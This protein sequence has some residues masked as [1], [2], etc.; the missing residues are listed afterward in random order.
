MSR[1]STQI[2]QHIAQLLDCTQQ[3]FYLNIIVPTIKRTLENK[4]HFLNNNTIVWQRRKKEEEGTRKETSHHSLDKS[5]EKLLTVT[6]RWILH[7][8][9]RRKAFLLS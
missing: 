1:V 2:K 6:D 7:L 4:P 9:V 3:S 8:S 5:P